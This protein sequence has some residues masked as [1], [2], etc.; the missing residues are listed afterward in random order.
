MKKFIYLCSLICALTMCAC[1]WYS[2]PLE[3]VYPGTDLSGGKK[4]NGGSTLTPEEIA[5]N[6]FESTLNST[7]YGW[8]ISAK[9]TDGQNCV[10]FFVFNTTDKTAK[11]I[12]NIGGT[13]KTINYATAVNKEGKVVIDLSGSDLELLGDN[14]LI[15]DEATEGNIKCTGIS[16][17]NS[18]TMTYASEDEV[19]DLSLI[20]K[21][22]KAG[23]ASGL[24]VD[25]NG[26]FIAHYY[27]NEADQTL[28]ITYME[29]GIIKF[30]SGAYTATGTSLST[31]VSFGNGLRLTGIEY[32]ES[33]AGKYSLSGAGVSNYKLASNKDVTATIT[34]NHEFKLFKN[35][36]YGEDADATM[37]AE[38]N[39][40][41]GFTQLEFNCGGWAHDNGI[42][43]SLVVCGDFSSIGY[44]NPYDFFVPKD[45]Y[46]KDDEPGRFF[47]EI[48][49]SSNPGLW[50]GTTV[51]N[52]AKSKIPTVMNTWF[53]SNGL[54]VVYEN[55]AEGNKY[56]YLFDPTTKK[57]F[58]FVQTA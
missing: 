11:V 20:S 19:K 36:Q 30:A 56:I 39:K 3:L 8:K 29:S 58:K 53:G 57:Y 18:Y 32:D 44:G 15:I 5:V 46:I 25:N 21:M 2:D 16:T 28:Y 43:A 1:N 22:H 35:R 40:W 34:N 52:E 42:S 23:M 14:A 4:D 7:D 17:N 9:T 31:D 55:N 41:N 49:D 47:F 10:V 37:L 6:A 13:A 45:G 48:R 26:K 54:F 38:M 51:Y 33:K 12:S 27:A 50:G 24:I